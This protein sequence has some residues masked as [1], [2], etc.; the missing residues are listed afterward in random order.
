[1][2]KRRIYYGWV[3]VAVGFLCYGFGVAPIFY[4]WGQY[5]IEMEADIG[6]TK[7]QRGSIFGLFSLV[8]AVCSPLAAMA[9]RRFGLRI[10]MT[11]GS[12]LCATAVTYMA[13]ADSILDC[14]IAFAL[15]GGLG[16]GFGAQMPWQT[17]PTYWFRK[18]RARA[19]ATILSAGG[20]IGFLVPLWCVYMLN[21]GGWREGWLLVAVISVAVAVISAIFVRNSP[22]D[23]G[24]RVDGDDPE[25]DPAGDGPIPQKSQANKSVKRDS[26]TRWTVREAIFTPQFALITLAAIAYNASWGSLATFGRDHFEAIGFTTLMAGGIIGARSLVSTF[27]RL[28]AFLGDFVSPPRLLGI[29]LLIEGLGMAGIIV[30]ETAWMAYACVF[31]LG[32]GFGTA[33]VTVPVVFAHFFG[34]AAFAGTQ[35]TSR[36]IAGIFKY[37]FPVLTGYIA[38]Q[39]GSFT[40]AFLVITVITLVGGAGAFLCPGPKK[41]RLTPEAKHK[42]V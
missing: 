32:V 10:V 39:T 24:L 9:I 42:D 18:Y 5:G 6:L 4:S 12:L 19:M 21:H 31:L 37:I 26:E 33:Y 35:G 29:A 40:L 36:M 17:L 15:L 16:V 8:Y 13:R 7:T 3:L 14:Y 11:F 27:G 20:L 22:E 30:A 23:H 38:D 25:S 28:A 1:M 2:T 34:P 41:K